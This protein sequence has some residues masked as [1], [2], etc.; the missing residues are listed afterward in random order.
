[1][2]DKKGSF[3]RGISLFLDRIYS[4]LVLKEMVK[5]PISPLK[6][7]SLTSRI[8]FSTKINKHFEFPRLK[9][10]LG[11]SGYIMI[12]I[13]MIMCNINYYIYIILINILI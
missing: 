5:S 11:V 2:R 10:S 9:K 3:F 12:N 8:F 13:Y 7:M 6:I 1:M 4:F